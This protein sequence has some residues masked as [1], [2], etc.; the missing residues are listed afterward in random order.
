[1]ILFENQF[2]IL[3]I[4]FFWSIQS[5]KTINEFSTEI[6]LESHD[7]VMIPI[8][9]I[10]G[11]VVTHIEHIITYENKLIIQKSTKNKG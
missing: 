11:S 9:H 1:M 7:K 10:F 2:S 6:F 8:V 4:Q 5:N 3:R